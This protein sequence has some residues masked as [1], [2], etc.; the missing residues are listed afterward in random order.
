MQ[1]T[2]DPGALFMQSEIL[3]PDELTYEALL[4]VFVDAGLDAQLEDD[5]LTVSPGVE[6]EMSADRE[7]VVHEPLDVVV[8]LSERDD[9][10]VLT[11]GFVIGGCRLEPGTDS[12]EERILQFCNRINAG[13]PAV[14]ASSDD[15]ETFTLDWHVPVVGGG[16]SRQSLVDA[17]GLFF[18]ATG[19]IRCGG[20][21]P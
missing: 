15:G 3:T 17:L 7:T 12:M 9:V 21:I 20:Y 5:T 4:G 19:L 11:V 2:V 14:R 10:G 13:M 16:I 8:Q 18:D 6:L 1:G